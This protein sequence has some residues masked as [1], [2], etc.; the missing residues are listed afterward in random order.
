MKNSNPMFPLAHRC[1]VMAL[2]STQLLAPSHAAGPAQTPL[3]GRV[4]AAVPPNVFFTFDDSGSMAWPFIP[5]SEGAT[6]FGVSNPSSAPD[7]ML[8]P[9]ERAANLFGSNSLCVAPTHN[10]SGTRYDLS[11]DSNKTYYMRFRS[12]YYN[13]LYYNPA[14]TYKPWRRSDGTEFP[15]II[16]PASA[17]VDPLNVVANNKGGLNITV[18]AR[19]SATANLTLSDTAP[20]NNVT[21]CNARNT[22]T[23]SDKRKF[24]AA[25]YYDYNQSTSK[26]T[27]F[28]INSSALP[29]KAASRTDCAGAT[30]TKAEELKNFANWFTYYRLRNFLAIGSTSRAF[31]TETSGIRVG[32]GRINYRPT[33][34]ADMIDNSPGTVVM[35][36][37]DFSPGT[38]TR[39]EFFNNLY[40]GPASGGT[41]L[42]HAMDDVGQYFSSN[43]AK[44]PWSSDPSSSTVGK[45]L[46]CRKSYHMLMTDGYWNSESAPTAGATADVDSTSMGTAIIN[47]AKT[48]SYKYNA[49]SPG[50][51]KDNWGS[52]LADVAMY[53]WLTDLRGDL[54]N[55]V[56]PAPD[57]D[58]TA[59]TGDHAF[60]QHLTT[61]T[62][63]LGVTGVTKDTSTLPAIGKWPRPDEGGSNKST[64]AA[65]A[66]VGN[67]SDL[68]TVDDLWHAAVNGRGDFVSAQNADEFEGA[69]H[70]FLNNVQGAQTIVSSVALSSIVLSDATVKYEPSYLAGLWIGD[71]KA[72]ASDNSG[73]TGT[74][75]WSANDQLPAANDRKIFTW[76]AASSA[77][78][79]FNT[80]MPTPL[81]SASTWGL[82]SAP[83]SDLINF[84]R[85]DR[86]KEDGINFRCRGTTTPSNCAKVIQSGQ[87][88][89]GDF[90]N[91]APVLIKGKLDMAY[92]YLPPLVS[93]GSSYRAFVKEKASRT[94]V[95]FAGAND[96]MLH[97]FKADSDTASG[98]TAGAEV[99]AFIPAAV[100][101]NLPRLADPKY[102]SRS[103]SSKAHR[104]YVDG[105]LSEADAYLSGAWANLVLGT[106]G[107]GARS[108]F[109][110]KVSTSAPTTF[111]TGNILWELNG[112]SSATDINK[113]G[114]V[115][116]PIATGPIKYGTS[117]KWVGIFGNGLDSP[118]GH[119]S[120]FIVDLATGQPLKV[121][122]AGSAT[123]NGLG[124]VALVQ[125]ANRMIIAAY[126]GDNKGNVWRFDLESSNSAEWKVGFGGAALYSAGSTKPFTA[127]PTFVRHPVKG[128]LVV[129]ASGRMIYEDDP[130]TTANEDD[131]TNT[132]TQ[133]IYG[134]WDPTLP[135]I[136]SLSGDAIANSADLVAQ[137]F[138]KI[139][140]S[141]PGDFWTVSSNTVPWSGSGKKL[142]WYVD[143]TMSSGQRNIYVPRIVNGLAMLPTV[144]PLGTS[145]DCDNSS[146]RTYMVLI[147]P[148]TGGRWSTP[149]VEVSGGATVAGYGYNSSGGDTATGLKPVGQVV[150]V[151]PDC[152]KIC[153][154]TD[155]DDKSN[156][157]LS[158]KQ[159][160]V[161]RFWNQIV[162]YPR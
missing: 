3:F 129:A 88:R 116:S 54:D 111:G 135:G 128:L 114:Y 35:G 100:I 50:I 5:D 107:A 86:S 103:D 19:S 67:L 8:V 7:L 23:V 96:G 65:R 101:P 74:L 153:T 130:S 89:L 55:L 92:E 72:Y 56:P 78:V 125:D 46:A 150:Q 134:L 18:T 120:L 27:A 17:P 6:Y 77:G 15:S 53:Y 80:G 119:A 66:N 12:A 102:G 139:T 112:S 113:L 42:R 38:A 83:S 141:T 154:G 22:S 99:V 146:A 137:T 121:I 82:A 79:A 140:T 155:C 108:V 105:P 36:V 144:A 48:K 31:A 2:C 70:D 136:A 25:L 91:S 149:T 118:D 160:G 32:Y 106:A 104:F 138:S 52:T 26:F 142:G 115:T 9:E 30:C 94:G 45:E 47:N 123:G 73:G 152:G 33:L 98:T 4:A 147:N 157:A 16:S 117:S 64:T 148:L 162:N 1:L 90:V 156:R 158:F 39:V 49:D 37:R 58:A 13:K 62:V 133:T 68:R 126:A 131:L 24:S 69:M 143:M 75:K 63:G 51:Y 95:I 161:Q 59:D 151:C 44:N 71:V 85:G 60:W 124:G 159:I 84:L 40:S 10:S 41:P 145:N 87:G 110:L 127:A 81:L 28:D 109:A 122:T 29:V 93:G 76:H 20:T 21:W 97:G 43:K 11:S 132:A 61:Y 14:I 34:A 57:S